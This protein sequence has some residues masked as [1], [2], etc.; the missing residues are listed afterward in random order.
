M[1]RSVGGQVD[2]IDG[3]R[4]MLPPVLKIVNVPFIY[5]AGAPSAIIEAGGNIERL[6]GAVDNAKAL[7]D[8]T[9]CHV[10]V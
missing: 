4:R 7:G 8:E 3:G 9:V 5:V 1:T 2:G 6:P 10:V